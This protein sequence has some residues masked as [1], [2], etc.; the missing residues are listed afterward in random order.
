MLLTLPAPLC[1]T[2]GGQRDQSVHLEKG[3]C[4]LSIPKLE[5]LLDLNDI[6]G[7][8]QDAAALLHRLGRRQPKVRCTWMHRLLREQRP[9]EHI[10]G[11][12]TY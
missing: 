12:V 6:A 11:I 8:K 4:H 9:S 1:R 5:I 7:T 3:H 2:L 10:H